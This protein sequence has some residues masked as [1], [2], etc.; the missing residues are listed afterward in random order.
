MVMNVFYEE[1][2]MLRAGTIL[3]DN[4]AS[5]Q[6]EAPHGKRSKIKANAV[7]LRFSQPSASELLQAAESMA[8][9]IDPEFLWSCSAQG[10]ELESIELAREY[11]GHEPGPVEQAAVLIR[12]HDAPMYFYK[13]GR[14]R[15]RAAPED[16][17]RAALAGLE[18]KRQQEAQKQAAILDLQQGRLPEWLAGDVPALLYHPDKN[19]LAYKTLDAASAILHLSIPEILQ[20]CGALK[21]SRAWHE[22]RFQYEYFGPFAAGE[23]YP[24]LQDH[25]SWP[26]AD[27]EAFSIDDASTTEIDDAFSVTERD[28][29]S[30]NVGIHIAAPGLGFCRDS[31]LDQVARQRLSTVYMPGNKIPMLPDNVIEAFTLAENRVNPVLSLYLR[32]R[33][34]DFAVLSRESVVE[35][36]R[37]GRNLRIHELEAHCDLA[38][39][40]SSH[41]YHGRLR[42]L[43]RLAE[44]LATARGVHE[45]APQLY[46]DYSFEVQD[47]RVNIAPRPRGSPLDTLVSELMIEVNTVWGKALLDAN[48]PALFRTQQGGKTGLSSKPGPHQGLGV[49]QYAWSSS[50]LRRYVDLVNQ[51]QL[52]A[53]MTSKEA[54]FSGSP[55]MLDELARRF[56]MAYEA[57]NE[58]QRSMERYWS[59]RW[60]MQEDIRECNALMLREGM[61]RLDGL[62][63]VCRVHGASQ[64]TAGT[65]VRVSVEHINL[66]EMTLSCHLRAVVEA[67]PEVSPA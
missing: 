2:G 20:H 23:V 61:A 15:Y 60:L 40:E 45:R 3:A 44:H 57:Y 51:W 1:E 16:N 56:E 27:A 48:L 32:V 54:P 67:L 62:P 34:T 46:Q 19:G 7:L 17:L 26:Q 8:A 10:V 58:F 37:V 47:D 24:V 66:W 11:F 43:L 35:R 9:E 52:L 53:W 42:V 12:L 5:L 41:P 65:L 13:K 39:E 50:P 6:V 14:G 22:G 31:A 64:V 55:D 30:W 18:R 29:G 25:S 4:E 63:L 59:L 38:A 36:I 49:P 21:D 28:D 33:R